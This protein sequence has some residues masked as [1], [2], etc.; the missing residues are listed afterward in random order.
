MSTYTQSIRVIYPRNGERIALRT[1]ENW[2]LDVEAAS[3]RG[4][5]TKF[6]I[7]TDRPYFYF[8]P[9]L[10][11]DGATVWAMGENCLAVATSGA[12]LDV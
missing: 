1:D 3:R 5:T 4:S 11:R 12:P 6:Q 7:K 10:I 2:D 9:A 8:K